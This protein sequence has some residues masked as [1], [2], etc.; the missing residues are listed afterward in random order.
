MDGNL[1]G[2]RRYFQALHFPARWPGGAPVRALEGATLVNLRHSAVV[3][4]VVAGRERV[5]SVRVVRVDRKRDGMRRAHNPPPVGAR[6]SALEDAA[7]RNRVHGRGVLRVDR[8]RVYTEVPQ[9]RVG[10]SPAAVR[11]PL[12]HPATVDA[13]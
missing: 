10:G 6:V 2:G 13:A 4:H 7:V 8:Q 1:T 12:E 3:I 9:A 11:A 5:D